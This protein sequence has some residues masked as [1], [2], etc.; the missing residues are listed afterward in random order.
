MTAKPDARVIL[1]DDPA[2]AHRIIPAADDTAVPAYATGLVSP[3][4]ATARTAG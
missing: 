4:G 2:H 3:G 1:A